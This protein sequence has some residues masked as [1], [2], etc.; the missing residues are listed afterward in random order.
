MTSNQQES[1]TTVLPSGRE[2]PGQQK[3]IAP[4]PLG[5]TPPQPAR[6]AAIERARWLGV[7][8]R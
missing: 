8:P 6:C 5:L 7:D 4:Y 3:W 2:L 1:K